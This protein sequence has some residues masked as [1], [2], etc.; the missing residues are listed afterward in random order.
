MARRHSISPPA[1]SWSRQRMLGLLAG[2]AIVG[3]ALVTGLVLLVVSALR[4]ADHHPASTRAVSPPPGSTLTPSSAGTVQSGSSPQAVEDELAARPM[5]HVDQAASEPGPVSTRD[6]GPAITL[7]SA[8]TT[9][10][11]GVASGFPHTVAGAMAQ[12]AAI[13]QAALQSGTLAGARAVITAWALPGGPT[14]TSWSGLAALAQF[15]DAAGLSGGGSPQLAIVVTPLMGQLKG[16]VGPDFAIPCVD[17]EI[18]AT[19]TTTARVGLADCERMAWTPDRH[20]P[21][22][23]RWMIGPGTEPADPPS[24]WPDTDTAISVGYRDLRHA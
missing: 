6:P 16:T 5:P 17:F 3:L 10:P 21:A 11:A 22:G 4:S 18:D 20:V 1:A 19:L 14:A 12:M 24:V 8:S 13:D 15:F 23:G 9:G 7:P 2:A